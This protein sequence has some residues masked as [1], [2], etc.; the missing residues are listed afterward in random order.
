MFSA[1]CLAKE[2]SDHGRAI[3][4]VLFLLLA[5]VYALSRVLPDWAAALLV[6]IAIAIVAGITLAA[7][8]RRLKT[9]EPA[10]K[11]TASLKENVQWAKQQTR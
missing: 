6:A 7:G 3:F 11:T 4:S 5:G 1:R 10:P 8:I 9:V 2:N